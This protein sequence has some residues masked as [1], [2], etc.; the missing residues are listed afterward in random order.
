MKLPLSYLPNIRFLSWC[1]LLAGIIAPAT[2]LAS[3]NPAEI[4]MQQDIQQRQ[5]EEQLRQTMQPE[6]DVRLHQKNTGETVNQLMGDDSSQ[7][8][9]AINEVVLEGEHHARFQFALKRALRETGFQAG[10]CLHAGNINQ[11][12][13][14]AQNALIG[15]GY[16][17]T[18]ILAAPQDLNSGKLQL[19]LIPSYLRSIRIDRSN[20]DQTH[21]GRIAAF[22]N[23][24][25]TRSN[26]LLN[27]R[28]LEQG[29]EN[30][31]RL[32][33][34]EADL[35]IVPVEGEPNQSDVVVQWRQRLLPY[36]VSVGMDNSGS[37]ATGKY[38]GNI[39]FSADNPLGLSDMFYVNYG[40]SIGGTPDE[41]SFD[42]HRKEGGSNNYAV[43]YSAPFGKWTWAFNHNG[44]RYH[45]AVSGLSE[46]YD[47]NG[48]SYNTDF[49]FNRLLY[50]DAKRK[51]YLGVKL[52]M[53]ETKSYIDDAE[54]TVQRRKT[55][56]WLAELS[57][58]EYIGRSTADFKLK[59]KRGTGMKD[60]LRAPEETF[61]E[62]TSRMKIWTAS[63]D[64]NTPFQIGKQLFAYDTSVHAQWNKTP[65]TSQDKLAIG[66]HHTVR[67]FDGEMSLSAERG[68]YWRNDLS[69]Q[70]KPGH[71]LY[72]GADVGH[73]S[74]QS[75]KWLSGQTLVGT[76]IGIRGQIKLGGNLHYD[77]FTGRALKKPEFFQSRKWA[78]GFQ[79]G[80]TF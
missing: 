14:L 62:G 65:L 61:G 43:H 24:F 78:S 20:D 34:A 77:I 28:D 7:P 59:Y 79:V 3:P 80:Y 5:R 21:A 44:Y 56:G 67:G 4:R 11:I 23:K 9:F 18:R 29:L 16:T 2:L 15:R 66:G 1:C 52:W 47:Y 70:F 33:T 31:K 13:S 41:E 22:Q 64:V 37:E 60:A 68:W 55:A 42:G 27:L 40:R 54:L 58:K 26:D 39:T 8:C 35:Q 49:G 53:R 17:T 48:K 51:T 50:R 75:A 45:Q 19:T 12:M 57:H 73:V 38:Q 63:A 10:K 46:V 76:A 74:G 71:Q 69:W 25:P 36:R 6:S 30:L 32:P 72:L